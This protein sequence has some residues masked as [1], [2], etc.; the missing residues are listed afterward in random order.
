ME[1]QDVQDVHSSWQSVITLILN[2][3]G[4]RG[5]GYIMGHAVYSDQVLLA[6]EGSLFSYQCWIWTMS[7]PSQCGKCDDGLDPA[8][9]LVVA[10]PED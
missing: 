10:I 1:C 2:Y 4:G 6:L 7:V 8:L 3:A 9:P 5:E